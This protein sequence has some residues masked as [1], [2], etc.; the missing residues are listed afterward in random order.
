MINALPLSRNRSPRAINPDATVS[1]ETL[2]GV[3]RIRDGGLT[4]P[5]LFRCHD[6]INDL[7]DLSIG[8]C[9]LKAGIEKS[10]MPY[11]MFRKSHCGW[12]QIAKQR[13]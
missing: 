11:L 2:I 8:E 13:Q 9:L 7:I 1:T 6:K 4:D 3:D 12:S 5:M 10:E